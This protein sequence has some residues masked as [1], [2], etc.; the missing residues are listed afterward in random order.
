MLTLSPEHWYAIYSWLA[1]GLYVGVA[2][3]GFRAALAGQKLFTADL[4]A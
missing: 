3:Y 1:M 2:I 4:D